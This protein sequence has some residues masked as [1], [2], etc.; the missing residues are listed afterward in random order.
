MLKYGGDIGL[1]TRRTM[2]L[3]VLP[4]GLRNDVLK[5]NIYDPDAI[6][7]WIKESQTWSRSEELMKRRKGAV[8]SVLIC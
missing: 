3:K 7:A 6:I 4:E 1:V 8:T 5:Q 2:L